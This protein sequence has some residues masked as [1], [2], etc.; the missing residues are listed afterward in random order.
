MNKKATIATVLLLIIVTMSGCNFTSD[1]SE[2]E[3]EEVT[4]VSLFK[5][6]KKDFYDL[7]APFEFAFYNGGAYHYVSEKI[8]GFSFAIE[9][10]EEQVYHED[11]KLLGIEVDIDKY[12]NKDIYV[13]MTIDEIN[14]FLP[15]QTVVE[16]NHSGGGSKYL[17]LAYTDGHMM[18]FSFDDNKSDSKSQSAAV[19]NKEKQK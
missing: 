13:G 4:A 12:V 6:D 14:A 19:F 7:Y 18:F 3:P 5:M 17:A 9:N 15:K 11:S 8:A 1:S 2:G 16:I 10:S